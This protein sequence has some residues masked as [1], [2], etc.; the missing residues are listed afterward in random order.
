MVSAGIVRA[1]AVGRPSTQPVTGKEALKHVDAVLSAPRDHVH[2][3]SSVWL[4]FL[5]YNNSDRPVVLAVP[6][7][8]A[9]P[10]D[11]NTMGLPADH[12]FSG[13][14]FRAL[15]ILDGQGRETGEE[16][17]YRPV[18]KV[19]RVKIAPRG[20]VGRRM[21]VS[22]HYSALRRSG[23]YELQWCPYG[24]EIKS[25]K[26]RLELKP[27]KQVVLV[28]N[29]GELRLELLYDKAPKHV[30]NFIELAESGFYNRTKLFR[31]Y[32]GIA[33]LGGCPIGDGTGMR[34]DGVTIPAEFND[35]P[36]EEGTVG[37]SLA[38]NDPNSA[39]SQFFICMRRVKAWDG[40]YTAFAKVV[41]LKSLETLRKIAQVEVDERDRPVRDIVIERVDVVT[42]P[43]DASNRDRRLSPMG[44]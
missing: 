43:R 12:V 18:G 38:G 21:D 2:T 11:P 31:V 23:L 7:V 37:M 22:D 14:R 33:A 13:E 17:M 30:A 9:A 16:V 36:F 1:E 4:D 29:M 6:D 24:G 44:Y 26:L 41:G 27:H 42:V 28:T 5:L 34:K 40:K 19:A 32:P 10:S 15:R 20:V 35:V 39:S 3:G 8:D 25:N